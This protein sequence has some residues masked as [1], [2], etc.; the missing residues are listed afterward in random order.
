MPSRVR[1]FYCCFLCCFLIPDDA[2]AAAPAFVALR[3]HRAKFL[4]LD[5][6][7]VRRAHVDQ[8]FVPESV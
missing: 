7:D 6:D 4:G 8:A 1:A 2:T 3:R 5:D